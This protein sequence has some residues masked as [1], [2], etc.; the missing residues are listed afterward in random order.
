[1]MWLMLN[2]FDHLEVGCNFEGLQGP[3]VAARA[4]LV[5]ADAMHWPSL[6]SGRHG[7]RSPTRAA[8]IWGTLL[9]F[10]SGCRC[11]E[12]AHHEQDRGPLPELKLLEPEEGERVQGRCAVLQGQ[13]PVVRAHVEGSAEPTSVEVGGGVLS[14]RNIGLFAQRNDGTTHAFLA[15]FGPLQAVREVELGRVHGA[16]DPPVAVMHD[17][18]LLGVISDNEAMGQTLQVVRVD[19]PWGKPRVTRGP[20]IS[21][22]RDDSWAASL[23]IGHTGNAVLVW[24]QYDRASARSRIW[25]QAFDATTLREKR[26]PQVL[27]SPEIDAEEP[28]LETGPS[29]FFLSYVELDAS[30]VVAA[31]DALMDEPARTLHVQLL[32]VSGIVSAPALSI[33]EPTEQLLAFDAL[34]VGPELYLAYRSGARGNTVEENAIH[35]ARLGAGGAVERSVA[36]HPLL[37]P[38][39]PL[40]LGEQATAPAERSRSGGAPWLLARGEETELLWAEIGDFNRIEL[41]VEPQ[42]N[43]RLPLARHGSQL[44]ALRAVGLDWAL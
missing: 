34:A 21:A 29:G 5:L 4:M 11:A 35:L 10:S 27:S 8:W 17:G 40:L 25:S 30:K 12:D 23:A 37:G 28:R 31:G 16:A 36:E 13:A 18:A 33:S 15:L 14:G 7:L 20:T 9:I 44:L 2:W 42:L 19:D 39:A 38:G 41:A 26:A 1:M 3:R 6:R 24:D 43:E 32:D 22:G